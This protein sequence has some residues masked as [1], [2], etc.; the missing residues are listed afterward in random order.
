MTFKIDL[1]QAALRAE[2]GFFAGMPLEVVEDAARRY[3]QFLALVKNYPD[4]RLAPAKDIDEMWH[5]HMLH[6]VA[7]YFGE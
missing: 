1:V 5:L 4:E 2:G 7:C 3:R 6:P